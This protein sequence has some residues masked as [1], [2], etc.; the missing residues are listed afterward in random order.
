[1]RGPN[2]GR[3]RHKVRSI[4]SIKQKT[5]IGRRVLGWV[6]DYFLPDAGHASELLQLAQRLLRGVVLALHGLAGAAGQAG[7]GQRFHVGFDGPLFA[8][9]IGVEDAFLV[10]AGHGGFSVHEAP[11][12]FAFECGVA[13]V[14]LGCCSLTP[15]KAPMT[16]TAASPPALAQPARRPSLSSKIKTEGPPWFPGWRSRQRK[17]GSPP[18]PEWT[19]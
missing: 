19:W 6:P 5:N 10:A 8:V 4:R 17:S 3:Q 18:S 1:M 9:N 14:S 16:V 12:K 2:L 13:F 15:A 11:V 7:I